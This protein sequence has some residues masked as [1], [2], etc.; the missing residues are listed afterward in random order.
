MLDIK[1]IR[2]EADLIKELLSSRNTEYKNII[3][4]ILD[5]DKKWREK[6]S[7][8]ENLEAS[9]NQL[10]KLVGQK[11][12]KGEDAEEELK[13]LNS[14]KEKLKE[15]S[16][17][18]P[19]FAEEQKKLLLELPNTPSSCTPKGKDEEDNK[20]ILEWGDKENLT[21]NL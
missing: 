9:R 10:S 18:E 1:K 13:E 5:V 20:L 6:L 4:Q 16:E 19:V 11:K 14:L 12:A 8:K 17:L 15:I 2:Q 21:L 3:D 7:E